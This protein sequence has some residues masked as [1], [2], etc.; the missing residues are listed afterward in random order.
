MD[1]LHKSTEY[2]KCMYMHNMVVGKN[3]NMDKEFCLLDEAIGINRE[4]LSSTIGHLEAM[5]HSE[6]S[7]WRY[8][9]N[10]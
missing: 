6:Q 5:N 9:C 1:A 10:T 2:Y 8:Y 7:N 3:F 4:I